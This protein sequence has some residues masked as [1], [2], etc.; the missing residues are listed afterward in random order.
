LFVA[1][2]RNFLQY[3]MPTPNVVTNHAPA[4]GLVEYHDI[5]G[6]PGQMFYRGAHQ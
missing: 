3:A 5:S 4:S 1:G 6:L 2:E